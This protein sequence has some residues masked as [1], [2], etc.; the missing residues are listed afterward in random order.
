MTENLTNRV[1][2]I[3]SRYMVLTKEVMPRIAR[4]PGVR[5][6]VVNDHCFQRIV[7]DN[8]CGGPWFDHLARPAYKH[9][10]KDQAIQAIDLCEAIIANRVDLYELNNRS[11][12][13]RGKRPRQRRAD[14]GLLPK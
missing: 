9:L 7:L 11:L 13:W 10:T 8:V 3:V 5:W 4:D 12:I 1:A 2:D 14:L 6:P